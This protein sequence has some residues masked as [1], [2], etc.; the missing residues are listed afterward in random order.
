MGKI[1]DRVRDRH[2]IAAIKIRMRETREA[3]ANLRV[4]LEKEQVKQHEQIDAIL[5]KNM[6]L[7]AETSA[8]MS[9]MS[10]IDPI[11]FHA[12]YKV[13]L[14]CEMPNRECETK[15]TEAPRQSCGKSWL[16]KWL[17]FRDDLKGG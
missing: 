1:I 9:S 13:G 5:A 3:E 6:E 11:T 12:L 10:L 4:W 17:R 15:V 14:G 8:I 16:W 7:S 2:E